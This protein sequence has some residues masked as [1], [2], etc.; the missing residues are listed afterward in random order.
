MK[1]IRPS[2]KSED[3]LFKAIQ[4]KV[5]AKPNGIIGCQTMSDLAVRLG[6]D[7]FPITLQIYGHPTIICRDILPFAPSEPLSRYANV[8]SGSFSYQKK[9]CSILISA[10]R[11]ICGSACHSFL[12]KPETVIYKA[13]TIG[14]KRCKYSSELPKNI[15][16]AVGGMGLLDFYNPKAEGFEGQ[17]ADVLRRTNHTVLGVKDGMLYL[18]YFA[19]MTAEAINNEIERNHICDMAILLDGGHIAA[20]N[21]A[22]SFSKLNTNQIQYYAIQA[23]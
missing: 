23:I 18:I 10:N 15:R 4:R 1:D 22:E 9:P 17:Y 8:I 16:W 19:N 20:M 12:D 21:G 6:A 2:T 13:D 5:F 14:I 3:A 11:T 7:C